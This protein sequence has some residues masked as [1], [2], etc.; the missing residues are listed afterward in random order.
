[1][2]TALITG[3]VGQDGAYLSRQL[4]ADGYRVIGTRPNIRPPAGFVEAYLPEIDLR[5]VDLTDQ[6]AM[7]R[8]LEEEYPM[9]STTSL[10]ISSVAASWSAPVEVAQ[11]N[12]VAV[13]QLLEAVRPLQDS[14]GYQ[15]RI[16]QASSAEMFGTP[17]VLPQ[18]ESHPIRPTN[19][20]AVAKAFAHFS[21]INYRDA[22]GM[23]VSTVILFNHESPLRPASFVTRKITTA[24]VNIAAGRQDH[25]EL[26]SLENRRDWG[27]AGDY[28]R[29]IALVG[30]RA[31]PDDF[32]LATGDSHP[33]QEF[34]ELAF[35][36][37]GI[38]DPSR[39]VTTNQAFVRPTDIP[40]L[41]GD[42]G[43]ARVALQWEPRTS[44]GEL[45]STMVSVDRD[46]LATGREHAEEYLLPMPSA[47]F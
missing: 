9:R 27:S 14:D 17:V 36:A 3:V 12:G 41:R 40:E 32:V 43:H 38:G 26:G 37:A 4:I 18:D 29:A 6:A 5:V 45:I 39:Y 2:R 35:D 28:A 13:V 16:V 7:L 44:F 34:V 31:E 15:P 20:Y 19:P 11:V 30:R 10:S 47:R 1:M 21:A 24:A 42:A 46:R 33:L 23:F 22:Y 25:L 8:L